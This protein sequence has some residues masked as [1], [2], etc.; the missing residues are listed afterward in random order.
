MGRDMT[1]ICQNPNFIG[2]DIKIIIDS[3]T[4]INLGINKFGIKLSKLY[5]FDSASE[6]RIIF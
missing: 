4:K 3:D 2:Q 5:I 1:L 6:K